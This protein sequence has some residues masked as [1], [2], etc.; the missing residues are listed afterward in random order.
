MASNEILIAGAAANDGLRQ[1]RVRSYVAASLAGMGL[2]P[3]PDAHQ[4]MVCRMVGW[5]PRRFENRIDRG[6]AAPVQTDWPAPPD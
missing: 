6:F 5:L 1:R 3:N 4:F 2:R